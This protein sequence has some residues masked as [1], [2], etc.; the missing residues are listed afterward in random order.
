MGLETIRGW[1]MGL[2][3]DG[4]PHVRHLPW[5]RILQSFPVREG[6]FLQT[7]DVKLLSTYKGGSE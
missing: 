5:V 1:R 3:E 2:K 7:Q 4:H 6:S